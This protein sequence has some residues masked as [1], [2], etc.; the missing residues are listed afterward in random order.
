[1]STL[2]SSDVTV[3][4]ATRPARSSSRS[5]SCLCID[6]ASSLV[7]A[8]VSP[9]WLRSCLWPARGRPRRRTRPGCAEG[10]SPPWRP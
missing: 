6:D 4:T 10:A 5:Q 1:M 8:S 2:F 7:L 3:V 9:S